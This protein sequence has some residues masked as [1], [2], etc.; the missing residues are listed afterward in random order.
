MQ[1]PTAASTPGSSH[2][3][4]GFQG[5][6][7]PDEPDEPDGGGS[8]DMAVDIPETVLNVSSSLLLVRP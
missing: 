7:E 3:D 5:T 6:D 1:P 4:E 8:V 2:C